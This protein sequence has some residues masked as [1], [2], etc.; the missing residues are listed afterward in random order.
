MKAK[1]ITRQQIEAE[2]PSQTAIIITGKRFDIPDQPTK[3]RICIKDFQS[4]EEAWLYCKANNIRRMIRN[5][6]E[7][8]SE[9]Q[10]EVKLLKLKKALREYPEAEYWRGV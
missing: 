5:G 4:R 3:V 2:N 1:T 10:V 7:K 6:K 8:G 9:V